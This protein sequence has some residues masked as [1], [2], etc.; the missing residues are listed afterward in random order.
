MLRLAKLGITGGLSCGKSTVCHLFRELGAYVIS[1]DEVVH[2]FL[3]PDS[4]AGKKIIE[5]YGP[6][7]VKDGKIDREK[8][9]E[10]VFQDQAK[11][12]QLEALLHPLVGEEIERAYNDANKKAIYPLFVAEVPLL[13]ESAMEKE[14]DWVLTVAADI[15]LA[16]E[17]FKGTPEEFQR[18]NSH[19]MSLQKKNEK[20]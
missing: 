3:T 16:K 8:I 2:Q 1:A 6:E 20:I 7:I 5:W 13:F 15:T 4:E 12:K 17:R 11:L 19:Q 10:I 18:R 14:F 9:A